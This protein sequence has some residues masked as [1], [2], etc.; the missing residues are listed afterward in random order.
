MTLKSMVR[1]SDK[2]PPVVFL[3][4]M[5]TPPGV[6]TPTYDHWST[7]TLAELFDECELSG[8]A[9]AI[10]DHWNGLY[11]GPPSTSPEWTRR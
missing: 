2:V 11:A 5:V 10:V 7:R 9:R 3:M 8:T 6:A 1:A 4:K